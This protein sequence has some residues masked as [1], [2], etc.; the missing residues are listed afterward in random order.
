MPSSGLRQ[1]KRDHDPSNEIAAAFEKWKLAE[2]ACRYAEPCPDA[3]MDSLVKIQS[4]AFDALQ[5][6]QP[7]NGEDMLLK[8]FP[9]LLRE[10]EPKS[11]ERPLCPAESRSYNYDDAFYVQLR[12]D[13][14]RVS[15]VLREAI[16]EPHPEQGRR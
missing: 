13:L 3:V 14:A 6:L 12:E 7:K 5:T 8:L 2:L 4:D 10:F 9:V 11:G 15:P 16:A 1:G